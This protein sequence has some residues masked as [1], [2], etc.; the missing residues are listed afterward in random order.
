MGSFG[1]YLPYPTI[2]LETDR[3]LLKC[4]KYLAGRMRP[5]LLVNNSIDNSTTHSST[6]S[7][8]RNFVITDSGSDWWS[9]PSTLIECPRHRREMRHLQPTILQPLGSM[10]FKHW[11]QFSLYQ[12]KRSWGCGDCDVTPSA[13]RSGVSQLA[14]NPRCHG[15]GSCW[16]SRPTQRIEARNNVA[17][18]V[19]G[20]GPMVRPHPGAGY[21]PEK[22]MCL[23]RFDVRGRDVIVFPQIRLCTP[24]FS[25]WVHSRLGRGFLRDTSGAGRGYSCTS[26]CWSSTVAAFISRFSCFGSNRTR[27]AWLQ[28]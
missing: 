23:A 15:K 16:S 20:L 12:T 26:Y 18:L 3:M 10:S 27:H 21:S 22:E 11:E 4:I 1:S 13:K 28:G 14:T 24:E 25:L 6:K 8:S 2:L 5:M 17:L 7:H 9:H 19:W